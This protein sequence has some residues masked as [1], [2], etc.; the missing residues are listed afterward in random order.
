[1]IAQL[2]GHHHGSYARPGPSSRLPFRHHSE[3]ALTSLLHSTLGG[4]L[5]NSDLKEILAAT[6]SGHYHVACTRVFELQHAKLPGGASVPKGEGLGGG[7]SVDH[8]NRYFDASRKVIREAKDRVKTEEEGG[9][10]ASAAAMATAGSRTRAPRRGSL[11]RRRGGRDSRRSSRS[12][13]RRRLR[14][15]TLTAE[16]GSCA[17]PL[18]PTFLASPPSPHVLVVATCLGVPPVVC[19]PHRRLPRNARLRLTG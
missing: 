18:P 8:P 16:G 6:K 10:G 1:M 5:A 13:V 3:Q 17:F 2:H 11:R 9:E 15:W 14:R 12:S 7:D 19:I 4:T